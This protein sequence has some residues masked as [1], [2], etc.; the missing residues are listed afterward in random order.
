MKCRTELE[1]KVDEITIV[2]ITTSQP[3]NTCVLEQ[4]AE[5][6]HETDD[7]Q[8]ETNG[9]TTSNGRV[10]RKTLYKRKLQRMRQS[11]RRQAKRR[12][13]TRRSVEKT[14]DCG[15]RP[16]EAARPNSSIDGNNEFSIFVSLIHELLNAWDLWEEIPAMYTSLAKSIEGGCLDEV[17]DQYLSQTNAALQIIEEIESR[18]KIRRSEI[19]SLWTLLSRVEM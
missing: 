10:K 8:L 1:V 17:F 16:A 3:V 4:R 12:A 5:P 14:A 7:G 2:V 13:K 11:R 15:Q 6:G 18:L 9:G 19:I